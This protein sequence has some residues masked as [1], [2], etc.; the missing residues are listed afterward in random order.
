MKPKVALV[1]VYDKRGL[2]SF[3][4]ALKEA[5]VEIYATSGTRKFLEERGIEAKSTDEITGFVE[6]LDG[7]V[8]TL[9]TKIH[10]GILARG[11]ERKELRKEGIVPIDMV[12]CNFYPYRLG[13]EEMD[14][15]GPAMI[16]AAAK[17]WKHVI[18]VS[19]PSQYKKVK[20][21]LRK[22]FDEGI[23]K[24]LAV[25]ALQRTSYYD[26]MILKHYGIEFP[27]LLCLPYLK[28]QDLRYGENPH[29]R[30]AFYIEENVKKAC[31]ATAR[32]LQGKELSYNNILDANHAIECVKEFDEPCAVIIKHA[33][34]SGIACG[35]SIE[36]AWKYAYETDVYS[37]FGG[38]VAFNRRVGRKLAEELNKIFLE[39]VIAPSFTKD[40]LKILSKKKNLRLLEIEGLDKE[41]R[42]KGI[43]VR[44][45]E[46]GLLLQEKD[47]KE[48]NPKEWKVVTKKKPSKKDIESMVFAIKCVRHI[49]SNA[50]VFVKDKRTVAIGGGQT[51]RVDATFIAIHKGKDRIKNSIMASDA[52]FP[53][54]DAVDLAAE[55]GVKA[56]VQPGGSIRDKEVIEA[57]DEHGII[58]VFTGQR[59]FLH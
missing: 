30:G 45:V 6:L 29:Q 5:G 22:G 11:N 38:V 23:R 26:A 40:A 54:R 10:A 43:E 17:N 50:V 46:G 34:P 21:Y 49:K 56:I 15:G 13:I 20:S 42:Q 37:P 47:I 27:S 3:C 7:R 48:P 35:K 25:E 39:V 4:K 44:S 12:V 8:K 16:R 2:V 51:A 57:A 24:E 28:K 9:H 59:C 32:Q 53:F 14:I 18:V 41:K 1:S 52:F 58:M 55:A 36:E 19:H 33:T 31:I